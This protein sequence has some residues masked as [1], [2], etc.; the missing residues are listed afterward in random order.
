LGAEPPEVVSGYYEVRRVDLHDSCA[1]EGE[2][3]PSSQS[4]Y[5]AELASDWLVPVR[6]DGPLLEI[7]GAAGWYPAAAIPLP[8]DGGDHDEAGSTGIGFVGLVYRMFP[9][10]WSSPA[11]G[12]SMSGHIQTWDNPVEVCQTSAS[13]FS[14]SAVVVDVDVLEVTTEGSY[15]EVDGARS[16]RTCDTVE[17][18][19]M[20]L[21]EECAPPCRFVFD[22][23]ALER[24]LEELDL[25]VPTFSEAPD[26]VV[27]PSRCEC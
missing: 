18:T 23:A 3:A 15:C 4:P 19:E 12:L 5:R 16:Q 11:F 1:L 26:R 25:P 20:T 2:T 14:W 13:R 10:R 24:E 8:W 7:P 21:V 22:R 27:Y 17:T 9:L 6:A